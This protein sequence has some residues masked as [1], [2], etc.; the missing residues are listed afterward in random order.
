[1]KTQ[2][3]KQ[4]PPNFWAVVVAITLMLLTFASFGQVRQGDFTRLNIRKE[5]HSGQYPLIQLADTAGQFKFL[6]MADP[7]DNLDGV[8]LRTLKRN[9]AANF[10]TLYVIGV[11][12]FIVAPPDTFY[13]SFTEQWLYSGDAIV[14]PDPG[15]KDSIYVSTGQSSVSANGWFGGGDGLSFGNQNY[16]KI[17]KWSQNV[18]RLRSTGLIDS[19]QFYDPLDFLNIGDQNPVRWLPN[20]LLLKADSGQFVWKGAA[21]LDTT[22]TVFGFDALPGAFDN[23][24]LIGHGA[25]ASKDSQ[26][27]LG[28]EDINEVFT[29]GYFSGSGFW[30]DGDSTYLRHLVNLAEADSG[31]FLQH[32]GDY[33]GWSEAE[34][35]V[36]SVFTEVLRTDTIYSIVSNIDTIYN[37]V[38]IT[39]TITTEITNTDTIYSVTSKTDT[40]YINNQMF[41]LDY[42]F[43]G[44]LLDGDQLYYSAEYEYWYPNR[45]LDRKVSVVNT[46]TLVSETP[47]FMHDEH[48]RTVTYGPGGT[49]YAIKLSESIIDRIEQSDSI[50]YN[51]TWLKNG[52]ELIIEPATIN[53]VDLGGLSL[54]STI[55]NG[56]TFIYDT[57][58]G[59]YIAGQFD[60]FQTDNVAL[61]YY[62]KSPDRYLTLTGANYGQA[63][64]LTGANYA[65]LKQSGLKSAIVQ[66]DSTGVDDIFTITV[67]TVRTN[68][69]KPLI[70]DTVYIS[71]LRVDTIFVANQPVSLVSD[72]LYHEATSTWLKNGDTIQSGSMSLKNFWSG[73]QAAY[74]AISPKDANTI[75][76][77]E[78]G[79]GLMHL[80]LLLLLFF[81]GMARG[82]SNWS[83]VYVG[84]KEMKAIYVGDKLVWDKPTPYEIDTVFLTTTKQTDFTI[85]IAC[86]QYNTVTIDWGDGTSTLVDDGNA[87]TKTWSAGGTQTVT[88]TGDM[89]KITAFECESQ[90]VTSLHLS[91]LLFN[92]TVLFVTDNQLTEINLPDQLVSLSIFSCSYNQ[93]TSL[94]L[95]SGLTTVDLLCDNNQLTSLT[96][97]S[98]LTTMS[99]FSC[100]SNQLTSLTLPSGLTTMSNFYCNS[101]QLTSLTLPSGLTTMSIFSCSSNQLTSLTLPSGLTTMS[102]F[103]CSSNQLTSLTLP[104][105]LTTLSSLLAYN[106]PNLTPPTISNIT[107]TTTL[108]FRRCNFDSGEMDNI[109]NQSLTIAA[110]D[111]SATLSI[112]NTGSG[113]GVN[114]KPSATGLTYVDQLRAIGWTVNIP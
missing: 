81:G 54:G 74:D 20:K 29:N 96:L 31:K 47:S 110:N 87:K 42:N 85:V 106:N 59:K 92:M 40:L 5:A 46:A 39:E 33:L 18:I 48:F 12:T 22:K 113:T 2:E 82:Q 19:L 56:G 10:D 63:G 45:A 70:G 68:Q 25:T 15:T 34:L 58:S 101:N 21:I 50:L 17:G 6:N 111:A 103:S 57:P 62:A 114:A 75:Y 61:I 69:I 14:F 95:P 41:A 91:D 51:E 49:G 78:Q 60:I 52:D 72:S 4:F 90:N 38:L 86:S 79:M 35:R 7:V 97:P 36:D 89:S 27:V 105:G 8:N 11:D 112:N 13:N 88:I 30:L 3:I 67:D 66:I 53:I 24:V 108:D 76:Y 1:M 26:L 98:G 32:F 93:L 28:G 80:I 9:I 104:S 100:S 94:T 64:L 73:T 37:E 43:T 16:P 99:I 65:S 71:A 23:V 84:E 77:I 83:G 107:S 55:P 102:S 109:L 44:G